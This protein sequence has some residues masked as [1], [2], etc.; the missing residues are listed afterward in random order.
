[1]PELSS[2]RIVLASRPLGAPRPSDFRLETATLPA[3]GPGEVLVRSIWLSLDPYMRGRMNEGPSYAAPVEIGGVMQGE[4]V[5]EVEAS[6]D[7]RFRPGDIVAGHGGWQ[8]RFV[9]PA[10]RLR[11]VDPADAPLST[12]LGVL[13]MPGMTAYTGLLGIGKPKP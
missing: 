10:D 4:A 6:E 5:G 9:L 12:A 8:S 11:K 7:G 3:P 13:G 1:M 2:R